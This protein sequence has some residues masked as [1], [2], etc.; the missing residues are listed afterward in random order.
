MKDDMARVWLEECPLNNDLIY[1]NSG[2]LGP[3]LKSVS[4]TVDF[5]RNE[6]IREGP[7]SAAGAK[8]ADSYFEMMKWT[9]RARQKV[10][11]WMKTS[12]A[13]VAITGNATDG[14]NLALTSISWKAG[15]HIVTT[16]EEHPALLY[17]LRR[18]E[19]RY[20]V[21]VDVIPFP[22]SDPDQDFFDALTDVL[23]PS[24]RM[25]AVSSVSHRSG[26]TLDLEEMITRLGSY[27]GWVLVDG[28]HAA[29][30]QPILVVPGVDFYVF[31]CHK[32]LFGPIGTGILWVSE[33]ALAETDGLLSGA[34]MMRENGERYSDRQGA[35]RYEFGTRDWA[36]AAG[37]VAAINFRQQWT[38]TEIAHYYLE[39]RTAYLRGYQQS[40]CSATVRGSGPILQIVV[41]ESSNISRALWETYQIIVKPDIGSIRVSL[42]P[43]LTPTIAE[44]IGFIMGKEIALWSC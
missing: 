44:D 11:Q 43:W 26:V 38:E 24:T 25:V 22:Q 12:A 31:P 23:K 5:L 6:W 32:W 13:S 36:L 28:S 2:T 30:T 19:D 3:P 8:G 33:K 1:L 35:W 40:G 41:P 39:L 37:I 9:D 4:H 14:I 34:P 29:G 27:E 20:G 42:P 16:D 7:G 15:D 17:P 10:A 18:L 21:I